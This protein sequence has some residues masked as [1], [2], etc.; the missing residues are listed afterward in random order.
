MKCPHCGYEVAE[1]TKKCPI[2]FNTIEVNKTESPPNTQMIGMEGSVQ[3]RVVVVNTSPTVK[4]VEPVKK[5]NETFFIVVI[6]VGVIVLGVLILS[7]LFGKDKNKDKNKTT[8]TT[9][10]KYVEP[11]KNIGYRSTYNYPLHIGETT[12]ASIYNEKTKT[13]TDVD[14]LGVKFSSKEEALGI[15]S[16]NALETLKEGFEWNSFTYEVHLNDLKKLDSKGISPVLNAKFF[17]WNGCEFVTYNE[18]N[19]FI[20]I[21]S[22]YNGKNIFNEEKATIQLLYQLPIDE[23]E[24][25]ICLGYYDETMGCFSK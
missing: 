18:I 22:I 15:A 20:N 16:M 6:I 10:T 8:I 7:M 23:S 13:Y 4:V 11:S 19:Y 3:P 5:K 2:C 21:Q 9:S 1:S 14:V 25:S 12:L 24:Y 17:K